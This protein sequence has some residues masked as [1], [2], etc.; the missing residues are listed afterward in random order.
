MTMKNLPNLVKV[1]ITDN[2]YSTTP[3]ALVC[4]AKILHVKDI[5]LRDWTK[6]RLPMFHNLI[7]L[8]LSLDWSFYE[9]ER[10]TS[11]LGMLPHF[12]KLQH[13]N[14]IQDCIGVLSNYFE[15]WNDPPIV[16]ECVSLQLKTFYIRGYGGSE[17][18]FG[19]AKYIMQHSKVLE[20]I[21]VKSAWG[22]GLEKNQMLLKLSSCTMGST[23]CKLF[24]D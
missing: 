24:F 23:K 21:T 5:M 13:F 8:E 19:L 11:L 12:P 6:L 17:Y 4:N 16:A 2:E 9:S 22:C 10:G 14:I 7:N 3:M 20:T 18:E 15:C 1:R